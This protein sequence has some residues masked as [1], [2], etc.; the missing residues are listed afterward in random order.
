MN[1]RARYIFLTI[2]AGLVVALYIG[3]LHHLTARAQPS[4]LG[5][6]LALLPMGLTTL[7]LAW[8][9]PRRAI[10]VSAWLGVAGLL[11]VNHELLAHQFKYIE[12]VQHAGTFACLAAVFGGSLT[13]NRTPMISV[14]ARTVHGPLPPQLADYTRKI[15]LARALLFG[16]LTVVSLGLFFTDRIAQWSLLAN[17]L[18]PI[19]IVAMFVGEYAV[20]CRLLPRSM[21]SGLIRSVRAA[22]PA[23]DRWAAHHATLKDQADDTK[24]PLE[25]AD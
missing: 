1:A 10:A 5:G 3:L 2:L 20:R 11:A 9:S 22:W 8:I 18:T 16:L 15:T 14:F 6:A 12:L 21:R 4:V 13:G 23:F 19:I 7:W 24:R 25:R 17:V